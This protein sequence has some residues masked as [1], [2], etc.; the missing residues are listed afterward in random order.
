M[1][2]FPPFT[3]TLV[4]V[5]MKPVSELWMRSFIWDSFLNCSGLGLFDILGFDFDMNGFEGHLSPLERGVF[6]EYRSDARESAVVENILSRENLF[7]GAGEGDAAF[8]P[9]AV[10]FCC[11]IVVGETGPL[12]PLFR[13]C[14]D[15]FSAGLASAAGWTTGFFRVGRSF[16]PSILRHGL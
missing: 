11:R 14:A 7:A 16:S 10:R 4:T 15:E 6:D 3:P 12:A 13:S 2:F 1:V 9:H 5:E 8:F